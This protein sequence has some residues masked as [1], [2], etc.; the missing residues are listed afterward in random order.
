VD[1][2]GSNNSSF[3]IARQV[4]HGV[5]AEDLEHHGGSLEFNSYG[6]LDLN[7]DTGISAG[8][9]DELASIVG[10]TRFIPIFTRVVNPG[11]NAVFTINAWL[12]VRMLDV[13]LTGAPSKKRVMIQPEIVVSKGGIYDG[14]TPK[15]HY[16]YSPVW[17]VR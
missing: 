11:D 5:T 2:G 3:D 15:T 12:G 13:K 16:V 9:K 7:G 14:G 1:I 17:L 8:I 6:E 10:E 4:V